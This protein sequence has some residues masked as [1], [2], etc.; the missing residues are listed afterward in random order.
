MLQQKKFTELP[1]LHGS[2]LRGEPACPWAEVSA[3]LDG[4]SCWTSVAE[5]GNYTLNYNCWEKT[6]LKPLTGVLLPTP[7]FSS[8][9]PCL[10]EA[11]GTEPAE[12]IL[13][14]IMG[15]V[16]T[17]EGWAGQRSSHMGS[18]GAK[19]AH[20]DGSSRTA[21]SWCAALWNSHFHLTTKAGRGDNWIFN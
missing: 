8:G 6:D 19:A 4:S 10:W 1:S 15:L 7:F 12:K 9:L 21:S 13:T 11:Q 3:T 2:W 18:V 20:W 16:Y 5:S 17:S 14:S